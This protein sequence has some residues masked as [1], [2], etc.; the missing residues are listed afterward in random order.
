MMVMKQSKQITFVLIFISIL[1]FLGSCEEK[2]VVPHEPEM[3]A[4]AVTDDGNGV[5]VAT[6]DGKEVAAAEEG[7]VVTLTATPAGACT[8]KQYVVEKGDVVLA[9]STVSVTTF[10]M[11]AEDVGIKAEFYIPGEKFGIEMVKIP[12]GT[13]MMGSLEDEPDRGSDETQHEVTLTNSFWMGKYE[14]TNAQYAEFLNAKGVVGTPDITHPYFLNGGVIFT[15]AVC[16]WGENDGQVL[17]YDGSSEPSFAT[18]NWGINWDESAGEWKPAE[19]YEDYPVVWV[20]WYGA[21]EYAAWVGGSLPTEAQWEYAARGGQSES[22]PF[23]IGDGTKLVPGMANFDLFSCYDLAEQGSYMNDDMSLNL[24]MTSPVGSYASYTNGYGLYDMHGNVS[25]W[26]MDLYDRENPDY[27][28]D[29]VTDPQG[30][31]TG[32]WH[33]MRGGNWFYQASFARSACRQFD[34]PDNPYLYIGF[35]VVI[36][37]K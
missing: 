12:A 33:I 14:V 7:D 27:G 20:S 24:G 36:V 19:G 23:G 34:A 3:Y 16:D 28:S 35:R 15:A 22:L 5:L 37:E 1:M 25:E 31:A 4:I 21:V 26:C 11:P 2:H 6:V 30:P 32:T 18:V 13:F 29:P 17:V 8:F 10:T 9:D